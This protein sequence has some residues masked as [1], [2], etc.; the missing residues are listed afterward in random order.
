MSQAITYEVA[1]L[2]KRGDI[3][4]H[5]ILEFGLV[6]GEKEP[7]T[8]TVTGK[9]RKIQGVEMYELPVKRNYGNKEATVLTRMSRDLWR[10]T[11]EKLTP[12]R[13]H[14]ERSVPTQAPEPEPSTADDKTPV[15]RVRRTR[16]TVTGRVVDDNATLLQNAQDQ[17]TSLRVRRTR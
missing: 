5:N 6:E 1:L 2:L 9:V 7:A 17:V 3:L 12:P 13:I 4:Y 14:R 8:C 10:T 15:M 16:T 11:R